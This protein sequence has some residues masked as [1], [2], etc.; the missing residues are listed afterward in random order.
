MSEEAFAGAAGSET[1][2]GAAER[3]EARDSE[4]SDQTS[5]A[6]GYSDDE[7]SEKVMAI[8]AEQ[9]M[10]EHQSVT[11]DSTPEDLGIDS[12]GVVDIVFAIE[13]AFDVSVP[14]NAND[15]TESEFDLS[16]V[17]SVIEG[18]KKLVR[19]KRSA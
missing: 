7:I 12:L 14:Y 5:K 13:E 8:I 6:A 4:M 9:T 3:G 19:E 1:T 10:I 18:V 16:N 15:P 11:L 2:T 17:A